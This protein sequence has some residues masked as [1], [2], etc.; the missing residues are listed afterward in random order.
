[1]HGTKSL[2]RTAAIVVLTLVL[3]SQLLAADFPP[4]AKWSVALGGPLG[5]GMSDAGGVGHGRFVPAVQLR[6]GRTDAFR[7]QVLANTASNTRSSRTA[8]R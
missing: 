5:D 7:K 4:A 3:S 2:I 1:M 6:E 8:S